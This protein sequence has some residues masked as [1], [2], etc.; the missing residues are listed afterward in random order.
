MAIGMLAT[1]GPLQLFIGD[2]HG[3]NT[4]AHQPIKVAAIEAHWDGS[5]PGALVLFAWPDEKAEMNRFEIAIPKAASLILRHDPE[6]LFPGLTSVPP[7]ERPPVVP[8]F[9]AFRLMVGAGLVIIA[10][11]LAGLW[12]WWRRRLFEA[13]WYLTLAAHGWW[14]GFVAV[15]A[16]W[17][18]TETGRQP[19]VAHGILRTADAVSP[20]PGA[21]VA[22]TLI[23]F[24]LVY[25]VVFSAG[26]Y[27]INRL[28]ARGPAGQ[29]VEA[30]VIG[31]PVRPLSSA[32][33]AGR[34]A[35][36]SGR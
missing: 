20:V 24:V 17:I 34:E 9:F 18:V 2:Q 35:V 6:G 5:K 10:A 33:A 23:L 30:P 36:S 15:I 22:S 29:S 26:I 27:F 21:S 32:A 7:A 25:G 19:W 1:L 28:I 3:L 13:R 8:V 4:L 31:T 14:L 16:G 11:G 12:L